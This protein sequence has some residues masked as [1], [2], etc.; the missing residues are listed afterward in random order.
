MSNQ[1]RLLIFFLLFKD[2][3]IYQYFDHAGN[4]RVSFTRN[5]AGALQLKDN[6]DYYPF[7]MN[8]LKMRNAYFGQGSYKN[9]KFGSKEL[10]EYGAYDFGA[11]I[12]MADIARWFAVDPMAEENPGP[13]V[14][15]Y[16]FNNPIMF[17]VGML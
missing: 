13:S 3:Y 9:Y 10:Q 17:T 8:H 2:Q 1:V 15:R 11:R 16:G 4:V 6:N 12:Y 14:Y 5:S 7:G